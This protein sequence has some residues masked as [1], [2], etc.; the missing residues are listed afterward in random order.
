M[1]MKINQNLLDAVRVIFRGKLILLN[2]LEKKIYTLYMIAQLIK[3][4]PALQVG[5]LVR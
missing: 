3:N 5:Y 1:K 2:A 4:P